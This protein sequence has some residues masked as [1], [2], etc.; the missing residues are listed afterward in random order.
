M[1]ARHFL[2]LND[3][4]ADELRFIIAQA[5]ELKRRHRQGEIIE[6]L[7]NR[8]LGMIFEKSSTRTRISFEAGMTQLGGAAL[9][10]SP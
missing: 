8:V 10:L 7:K 1:A 3:I 2:T 9:F 5:I 6:T 4:S